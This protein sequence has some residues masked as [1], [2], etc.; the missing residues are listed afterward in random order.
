[1]HVL[2]GSN[3]VK[4]VLQVLHNSGSAVSEQELHGVKRLV[5]LDPVFIREL[6]F[7]PQMLHDD[8]VLIPSMNMTYQS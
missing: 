4:I 5:D 2:Q 1:M 8:V 7:G 3:F 6:R